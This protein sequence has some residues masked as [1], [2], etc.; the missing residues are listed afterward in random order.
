MALLIGCK[1][2]K[3]VGW[4]MTTGKHSYTPEEVGFTPMTGEEQKTL[5]SIK[6]TKS[7]YDWCKKMEVTIEILSELNQA[8][9]RFTRLTNITEI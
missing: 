7:L 1:L 4:D 8:D 9:A 2:I 5:D 6:G 3:T